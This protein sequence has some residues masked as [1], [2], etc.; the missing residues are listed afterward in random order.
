MNKLGYEDI[1]EEGLSGVFFAKQSGVNYHRG[2]VFTK[3]GKN[4]IG[5]ISIYLYH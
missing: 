1:V 3:D 2:I 5:E 4:Q